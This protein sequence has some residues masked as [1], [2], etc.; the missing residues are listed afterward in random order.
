MNTFKLTIKHGQRVHFDIVSVF[1]VTGQFILVVLNGNKT[2]WVS[3]HVFV[4]FVQ[5]KEIGHCCI[6]GGTNY[7][8]KRVTYNKEFISE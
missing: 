6:Y 4:W 8:E 1:D 2:T 5:A 3:V 7:S